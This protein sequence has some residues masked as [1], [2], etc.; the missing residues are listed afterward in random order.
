[1]KFALII[2][3]AILLICLLFC[4]VSLATNGWITGEFRTISISGGLFTLYF[5]DV[6]V[7]YSMLHESKKE[8]I[9]KLPSDSGKSQNRTAF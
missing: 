2:A 6:N 7:G 1:M 4:I 8:I 3:C 5:D 9:D